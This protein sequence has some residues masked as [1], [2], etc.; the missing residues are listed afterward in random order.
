M[1]RIRALFDHAVHTDARCCRADVTAEEGS[2]DRFLDA[3]DW[4]MDNIIRA[5]KRQQMRENG[6]S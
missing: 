6:Q 1:L 2:Y 5:K 3:D 4:Y